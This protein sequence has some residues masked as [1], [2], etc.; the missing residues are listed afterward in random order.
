MTRLRLHDQDSIFRGYTDSSFIKP[1]ITIAREP[2][3]GGAPIAQAVADKLGFTLIDEQIVDQIAHS[4]KKRKTIIQEVD[5]KSRDHITDMVQSLFNPEYVDDI[6]YLVELAKIILAYASKGKVVILGRGANFIT[7]FATGLHVNI[8]APYD[9]RVKRAMDF[10]GLNRA[11]AKAV[12]A[13][14]EKEREKFVRQY[15]R[16]DLSS[17]NAYDITLNTT[18]FRVDEARDVI[19]EAF[20]RK[21]SRSVKYGSTSNASSKP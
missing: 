20:Y 15:L 8:T 1:F 2:G 4:T 7:P 12:I 19:V 5:E 21:F 9:V 18:Y 11:Q 10:E 14:V 3:S 6:K 17:R 16:Q 13:S